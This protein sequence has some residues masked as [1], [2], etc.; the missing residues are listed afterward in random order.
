MDD[1][2]LFPRHKHKIAKK[3]YR[4]HESIQIIHVKISRWFIIWPQKSTTRQGKCSQD[5]ESEFSFDYIVTGFSAFKVD[6]PKTISKTILAKCQGTKKQHKKLK[7]H[8]IKIKITNEQKTKHIP[9]G[10]TQGDIQGLR[11]SGETEV[12][13]TG[14]DWGPP[15]GCGNG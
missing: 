2:F 5:K 6:N 14:G 10:K 11:S 13:D 7:Q 9:W 12:I 3:I 4:K 8:T 15:A 1:F